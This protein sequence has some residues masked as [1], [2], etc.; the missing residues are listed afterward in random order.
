MVV[1]SDLIV[2]D[3]PMGHLWYLRWCGSIPV[4]WRQQAWLLARLVCTSF[5]GKWKLRDSLVATIIYHIVL[6][7]PAQW[8][9]STQERYE[10]RYHGKCNEI[11]FIACQRRCFSCVIPFHCL[12]EAMFYLCHSISL[13][14]R[15]DI[16]AVSFYFIACQ[17]RCYSHFIACQWRCF[18]CQVM[19]S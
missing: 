7:V 3:V 10:M 15:G 12:P 9:V 11:Y 1:G 17:R 2:E 19:I 5:S 13:L 18:Y 4:T 8:F 6:A 14:A 16:L